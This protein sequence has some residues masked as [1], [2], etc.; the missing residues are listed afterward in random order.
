[1]N[2]IQPN[3]RFSQPLMHNLSDST[4]LHVRSIYKEEDSVY[5]EIVSD[6]DKD[7]GTFLVAS[8][9]SAH[10]GHYVILEWT[11]DITVDLEAI[12]LFLIK[13]L[14]GRKIAAYSPAA[15]QDLIDSAEAGSWQS[16]PSDDLLKQ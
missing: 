15:A 14:P 8:A 7:A 3:S 10:D 16:C 6:Q 13:L 4:K 1:M 11:A 9:W 12:P 2:S 5:L